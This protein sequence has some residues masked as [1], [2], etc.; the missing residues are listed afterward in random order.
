M[1]KVGQG[2]PAHVELATTAICVMALALAVVLDLTGLADRMDA[3]L[4]FVFLPKGMKAPMRDLDPLILWLATAFLSLALPA[5]I[6]NITEMWRRLLIWSLTFAITLLWGPVLL[7]SSY[8]PPLR[9]HSLR[10][11]GLDSVRFFMPA[12]TSCRW[13]SLKKN[14]TR[15]TDGP[16]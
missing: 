5:V 4:G 8:K 12:R 2:H 10:C 11:F 7:L 6:L 15:N 13:T 9:C 1:K 3:A 14:E 16:R